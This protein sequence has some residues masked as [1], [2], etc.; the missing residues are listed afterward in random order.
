MNLTRTYIS[1]HQDFV[2]PLILKYAEEWKTSRNPI[3]RPVWWVSP[4]D[5]NTFTINDEFLIGDEVRVHCLSF[6]TGAKI[7]REKL[8]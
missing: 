7:E 3:Y 8:E 5:P 4:D 1:K 6:T 2:V